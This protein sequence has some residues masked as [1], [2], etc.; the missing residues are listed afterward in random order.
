MSRTTITQNGQSSYERA[1][2]KRQ[3]FIK[4]LLRPLTQCSRN[5]AHNPA[6]PCANQRQKQT[7]THSEALATLDTNTKHHSSAPPNNSTS[8]RETQIHKQSRKTSSLTHPSNLD[9][10]QT[11]LAKDTVMPDNTADSPPDTSALNSQ[12]VQAVDLSNFQNSQYAPQLVS[13][14]AEVMATQTAGHATQNAEAYMNNIMQIAV[15]A[16]AVVAAKI[17]ASPATAAT[18]A[19]AL[20][21]LQGMVTAAI[22]AYGTASEK[23]GTSA[24]TIIE[25]TKSS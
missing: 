13:I 20:T 12:I 10:Q 21:E 5:I 2:Q 18:D 22:S 17:A 11:P 19:T 25:N 16:Q 6:A 23:A 1:L 24:A 4:G 9:K 14:P 8:T 15:A 3:N 7:P